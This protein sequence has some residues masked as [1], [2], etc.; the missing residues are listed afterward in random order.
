VQAAKTRTR[1]YRSTRN[2]I[3]MIYLLAGKH[4]FDLLA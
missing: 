2:F 4:K 1:G 3:I